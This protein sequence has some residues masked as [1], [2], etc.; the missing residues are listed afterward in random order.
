MTKT[1]V[2][3]LIEKD[4]HQADDKGSVFAYF[5]NED[6]FDCYGNKPSYAHIGQHSGCSADYASACMH[7][8]PKQYADLK[9]ELESIGYELNII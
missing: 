8:S 9:Q 3:F 6:D 7:A 2:I 4:E 5:P 1:D